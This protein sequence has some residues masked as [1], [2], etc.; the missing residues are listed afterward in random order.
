MVLEPA[1]GWNAQSDHF[2]M[3]AMQQAQEHE[4]I[5]KMNW[6]KLRAGLAAAAT[7][8]LDLK[9]KTGAGKATL[10]AIGSF[11]EAMLG[12]RAE[13]LKAIIAQAGKGGEEIPAQAAAE[14]AELSYKAKLAARLKQQS[15]SKPVSNP[16]RRL[17]PLKG[18]ASAPVLEQ[19]SVLQH[20]IDMVRPPTRDLL[21]K[22]GKSLAST[23][24][25]PAV[26]APSEA[27]ESNAS[28]RPY[29]KVPEHL[30]ESGQMLRSSGSDML[31]LP[32]VALQSSLSK[33]TR[34][35]DFGVPEDLWVSTSSSIPNKYKKKRKTRK[36]PDHRGIYLSSARPGAMGSGTRSTSH[37]SST[38]SRSSSRLLEEPP[39]RRL[40][41]RP[42]PPPPL[43]LPPSP[44][45]S[46]TRSMHDSEFRT[47]RELIV[48][49]REQQQQGT[50]LSR[51][52]A[53]LQDDLDWLHKRIENEIRAMAT[54]I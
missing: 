36:V 54:P 2:L 19:H 44:S 29:T 5:R 20:D 14:E 9:G 26:S 15:G 32:S 49:A 21:V 24:G 52:R 3:L 6:D 4:R 25:L 18:S 39:S 11:S 23:V 47:A 13:R 31:L 42:P 41:P 53:R 17:K 1:L 8:R 16:P 33:V 37:F 43:R 35:L 27:G 46:S 22:L 40:P 30:A 48:R 34:E 38:V 51:S 12:S 50:A 28:S 10:F 7:G 45:K